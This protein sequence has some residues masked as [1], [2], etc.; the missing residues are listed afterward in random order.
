MFDRQKITARNRRTARTALSTHDD[1]VEIL[2]RMPNLDANNGCPFSRQI[3]IT[4]S[5]C[6]FDTALKE[7]TLTSSMINATTM[8]KQSYLHTMN[9]FLK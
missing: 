8:K 3:S 5:L 7:S 1:S 2:P 9:M 4:D 6:S